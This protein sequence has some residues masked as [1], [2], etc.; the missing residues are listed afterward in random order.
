[1]QA[2][3]DW[4]GSA[5]FRLILGETPTTETVVFLDAY[6]DRVPNAP[7]SGLQ[8]DDVDR[9]DWILVGHSHFDH[10]WGAERI[11]RNTGATVV[12]SYETI[13]LMADQG[14]AREQLIPV[15]GGERIRLA[16]GVVAS[17]YPEPALVRV[18]AHADGAVG[19][20][21][22]SATSGSRGRSNRSAS[23]GSARTSRASARRCSST[24]RAGRA[25]R[26]R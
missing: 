26:T 6:L 12:G 20:S 21:S 13:R 16:D 5:T 17:V 22:A 7:Q 3:L 15:Q 11:A 1:M 23:P 9:C 25:Q 19:V 2:T 24:S 4:A 10:A 14:V 8:V 18:V